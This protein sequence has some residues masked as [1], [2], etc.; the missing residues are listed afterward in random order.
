M[1]AILR[2]RHVARQLESTEVVGSTEVT[3]LETIVTLDRRHH[4]LPDRQRHV[5]WPRRVADA[6]SRILLAGHALPGRESQTPVEAAE[7]RRVVGDL[8]VRAHRG[9]AGRAERRI[10]LRDARDAD[11]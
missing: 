4:R 3:R 2:L 5:Q 11:V 7:R 9:V 8:V 1:L 6:A 10:E